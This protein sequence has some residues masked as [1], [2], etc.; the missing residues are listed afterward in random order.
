MAT[1]DIQISELNEITT[2]SDINE[3]I[4]NNKENVGDTGITKKIKTCNFLSQGIVKTENIDDEA[5]TGDKI[6]SRTITN[7][8]ISLNTITGNEIQNSGIVNANLNTNS[9]DNRVLNN[10]CSFTV[11]S[12]SSNTSCVSQKLSIGASA[13]GNTMSINGIDYSFPTNQ[14]NNYFLKTD[15]Y[16]NLS[17]S[18]AVPGNGTSIVYSDIVP[19]GTIMPWTGSSTSVPEK[20]LLCDGSQFDINEHPSLSAVLGDTYGAIMEIYIDY[21]IF[22]DVYR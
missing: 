5:V 10:S 2:N 17:W 3:I 20:W 11:N 14:L 21:L 22:K 15:G 7:A 8:D 9:V 18:E 6:A 13:G 16:G 19:V 12:I 4:V 1:Q